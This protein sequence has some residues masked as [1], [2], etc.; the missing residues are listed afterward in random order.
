MYPWKFLRKNNFRNIYIIFYT[1]FGL[2][3]KKRLVGKKIFSRVVT[4]A[5]R[6]SRG[7]LWEKVLFF[8]KKSFVC[9]SVL[10]FEQFFLYTDKKQ[11]GCQRNNLLIQKKVGG[12]NLWGHCFF[13]IIFGFRA[14]KFEQLDKKYSQDCQNSIQS[15][16]R[17]IFRTFL[18]NEE[19]LLNVFG[20]WAKLLNFC[21]DFFVKFLKTAAYRCS[22]TFWGSFGE[23]RNSLI[24]F[25]L[26]AKVTIF[27][28][29][30]SAGCQSAIQVSS[31]KLG[32][33][34]IKIFFNIII[35]FG[36]SMSFFR[37]LAKKL[38]RCVETV[39]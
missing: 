25:G 5:I 17:N 31:A 15:V 24:V 38:V 7:I 11:S 6:A 14:E 36:L 37:I 29:K 10:E 12:R 4:T 22:R 26:W 21:C 8:K 20:Q 9:S 3:S 23:K 1:F 28:Q 27:W 33:K 35:S 30:I 16:Q 13:L 18:W 2:W 34:M 19:T 39:I 32:Q